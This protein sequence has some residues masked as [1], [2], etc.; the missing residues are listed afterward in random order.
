MATAAL[1]RIAPPV[2]PSGLR[3]DVLQR[4][5]A[6]D[7]QTHAQ[8][9]GVTAG[10]DSEELRQAYQRLAR[11]FHP[12]TLDATARDL[13]PQ[14]QAIF[15]RA[16][17][18]YKALSAGRPVAPRRPRPRA[19]ATELAAPRPRA[20]APAARVVE[21]AEARPHAPRAERARLPLVYPAPATKGAP[22]EPPRRPDVD[23]AL[24]EAQ[25]CLDRD[26]AHGAVGVLHGVLARCDAEEGRRVR[27]LLARGY[28]RVPRWRR[29]AL[30]QLRS[31]VEEQPQDAEALALLG[32]LYRTEG[33]LARAETMLARALAAD[34]GLGSV[35]ATLREVQAE[36]EARAAEKAQAA[37]PPRRGLW[38]RFLRRN[39]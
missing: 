6:L 19:C 9:L 33:L 7:G 18:A 10:A 29:Y 12:D 23:E 14:C 16:T 8:V 25:A 1:P 37:P 30:G 27:R 17:E 21:T 32:T 35:R 22:G 11:R 39:V 26:D 36:R 3:H 31:L 13:A 20:E 34:S 38:K 4:Y 15:I 5:Q 2:A 28:M 24:R